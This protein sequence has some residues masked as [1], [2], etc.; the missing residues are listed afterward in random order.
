MTNIKKWLT[1]HEEPYQEEE[2]YIQHEGKRY[3][4]NPL[5]QKTHNQKTIQIPVSDLK[6][7]LDHGTPDRE[8]V[9]KANINTPLLILRWKNRWVVIDGFHRLAKAV[10]ENALTLPAKEVHHSWFKELSN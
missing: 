1:G 5:F 6:W 2:S 4:L 10:S 3:P 8:R 7:Q 9:K